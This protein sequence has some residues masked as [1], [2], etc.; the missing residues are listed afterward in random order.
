MRRP[1][2]VV[3]LVVGVVSALE[4]QWGSRYSEERTAQL[5]A[6]NV[7]VVRIEAR[8]GGLRVVGRTGVDEVRV[9]GTARANA[10]RWLQDIQIVAER[11]GDEVR[12]VAVIPDLDWRRSLGNVER[13]LD[14]VIEL[15]AGVAVDVSDTSGDVAISGT[16]D[17]D[18]EDS[19]GNVRIESVAG[20]VRVRDGSGEV[21]I[22]D[23]AGNV[24]VRS[25]GSGD[26]NIY[27]V[28]RSVLVEEDGSGDITVRRV[29]G[30][31]TVRRDGS[32]GI[33]STSVEGTISVPSRYSR[34]GRRYSMIRME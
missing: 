3:A 26:L 7:R 24:T 25:D 6:R 5:D 18:V 34:S 14:L 27:D 29:G 11:R 9:R 22:R 16:G 32:G 1:L 10:E 21:E 4:A 23:V 15:P 33:H 31:F 30:S 12:I 13:A 28:R 8:A 2:I 17:V 19:S 20:D